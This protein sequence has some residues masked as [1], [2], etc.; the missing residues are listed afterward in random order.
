MEDCYSSG[1][2]EITGKVLTVINM[3]VETVIYIYIYVVRY[4]TESQEFYMIFRGKV[5]SRRCHNVLIM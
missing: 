1:N 5:S 3:K 2:F 4:P